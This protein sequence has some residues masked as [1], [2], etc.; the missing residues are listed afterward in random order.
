M[1]QFLAGT[2]DGSAI[3]IYLN[4]TKV[5]SQ[6]F[7]GALSPSYNYLVIGLWETSFNGLIDDVSLWTVARSQSE[8]QADMNSSP[9]GNVPGLV[10]YWQFNQSSGQTVVDSTNYHNNGVLGAAGDPAWVPANRFPIFII[11]PHIILPIIPTAT[12]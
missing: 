12:P 11:N 1:W 4:G 6:P 2:Y 10:G 9:T 8:V 3:T 5:A 7:S